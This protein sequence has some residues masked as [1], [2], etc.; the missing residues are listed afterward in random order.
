M[1]IQ[2]LMSDLT[3]YLADDANRA[4]ASR[5][6]ARVPRFPTD[7]PELALM[8]FLGGNE[9]VDLLDDAFPDDFADHHVTALLADMDWY[10]FL[11]SIVAEVE[12][13]R[14]RDLCDDLER[15]VGIAA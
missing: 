7:S 11:G 14:F 2:E 8:G 1:T 13:A 10:D 4:R 5:A 9:Q 15:Y 6:V 3:T 12:E